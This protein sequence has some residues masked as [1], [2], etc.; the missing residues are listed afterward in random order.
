MTNDTK[1][2]LPQTRP[3]VNQHEASSRRHTP[4]DLPPYAPGDSVYTP[5]ALVQATG[6][7]YG[8]MDNVPQNTSI[9]NRMCSLPNDTEMRSSISSF[10]PS[11]DLN[12]ILHVQEGIYG[13][14]LVKE[15]DDWSQRNITVRMSSGSRLPDLLD[16]I[17]HDVR[18]NSLART[19]DIFVHLGT[20]DPNEKKKLL[21]N[22]CFR[23]NIEIL[24][25]RS[26]SSS[27][28]G[29]G[30]L[31]VQV[32]YGEIA[33]DFGKPLSR[34]PAAIFESLGLA[35]MKGDVSLKNVGVLQRTRI[36]T[37]RGS[38][39]GSLV[40]PGAADI[41]ADSGSIDLRVHSTALGNGQYPRSLDLMLGSKSGDVDLKLSPSFNGHFDLTS[42]ASKPT[43]EAS[44]WV[45]ITSNKTTKITGWVSDNGWEPSYFLPRIEMYSGNGQVSAAI[46][47][48]F[49]EY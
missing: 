22:N 12:F 14:I 46:G 5:G 17:T 26:S 37:E 28:T 40:T 13:N 30:R 31:E 35:T 33:L 45:Y 43:I 42:A 38:V 34:K 9:S 47:R 36:R 39:K 3:S 27:S 25:P 29:S 6:R 18:F 32:A 19:A 21:D 48:I 7:N 23:T 20:N 24:Y 8:A 15:S 10:P 49:L 11:K 41:S 1:P 44:T 2:L 4:E 16:T